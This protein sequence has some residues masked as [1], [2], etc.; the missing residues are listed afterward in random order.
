MRLGFI[1]AGKMATALARGFVEGN[2]VKSASS[3]AAS[4]PIQ[5]SHLLGNIIF[6]T[7]SLYISFKVNLLIDGMKQLGCSGMHCNKT[8]VGESDVVVIA[9][10]PHIV[11]R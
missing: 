7:F 2:A 3:I 9:V 1:G 4:C 8:L 10:K 11:P 5:D 6:I